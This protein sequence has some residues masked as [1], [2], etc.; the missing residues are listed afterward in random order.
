[1]PRHRDVKELSQDGEAAKRQCWGGRLTTLGPV[2]GLLHQA[3]R[4]MSVRAERASEG[5]PSSAWAGSLDKAQV[6]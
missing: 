4:R 6:A 2:R 3:P 1:M 5:A